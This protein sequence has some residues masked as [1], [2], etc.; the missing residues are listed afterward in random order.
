MPLNDCEKTCD[1]EEPSEKAV[2]NKESK[3][4]TQ[5]NPP[6]QKKPHTTLGTY[7]PA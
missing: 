2:H 7:L 6:T 5:K 1:S 4:H 3:N